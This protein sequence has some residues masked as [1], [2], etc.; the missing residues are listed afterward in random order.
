[1][2]LLNPQLA[3]TLS[4]WP[5]SQSLEVC[6]YVEKLTLLGIHH[7]LATIT[8]RYKPEFS[9]AAISLQSMLPGSSPAKKHH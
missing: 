1:L 7:L 9:G 3:F 6:P 8:V 5:S 2:T 4:V